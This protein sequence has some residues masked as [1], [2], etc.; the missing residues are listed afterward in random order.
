MADEQTTT[1]HYDPGWIA[2]AGGYLHPNN[3]KSVHEGSLSKSL[4]EDT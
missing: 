1:F 3:G 2:T 4:T